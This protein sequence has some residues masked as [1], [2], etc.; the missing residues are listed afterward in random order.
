MSD[1]EEIDLARRCF[2]RRATGAAGGI[3][4]AMTAVPFVRYWMPSTDTEVAGAP[5]QVDISALQPKQQLTVPWRG[6]PVWII[7]R[8]PE[9]IADLPKLNPELRDP[10]SL[11]DQQPPYAKN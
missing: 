2:L 3:G 4:I 11:E 8:T 1:E 9:M 10:N 6:Q 7:K 5:I